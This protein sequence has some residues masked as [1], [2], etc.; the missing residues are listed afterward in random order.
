MTCNQ[1][2]DS[3]QYLQEHPILLDEY[4]CAISMP[5]GMQSA[6]R[7][8]NNL[9]A[10]ASDSHECVGTDKGSKPNLLDEVSCAISIPYGMQSAARLLTL[11]AAKISSRFTKPLTNNVHLGICCAI[12]S[13]PSAAPFIKHLTHNVFLDL[14]RDQLSAISGAI[15]QALDK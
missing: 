6:A 3:W 15:H 9:P 1:R 13:L 8:W 5:F 14:L 10:T 2:R 12:S 4:S 11:T 7:L